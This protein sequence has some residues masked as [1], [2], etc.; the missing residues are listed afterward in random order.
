MLERKLFEKIETLPEAAWWDFSKEFAPSRLGQIGFLNFIFRVQYAFR[1]LSDTSP[2]P[3]PP[4][5]LA[6]RE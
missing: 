5:Q 1:I 4:I 3:S 6:E 2:Q